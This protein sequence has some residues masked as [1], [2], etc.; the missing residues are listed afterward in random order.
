ML[1][2]YDLQDLLAA[3]APRDVWIVSSTD[4]LRHE[5]P[6]SEVKKEYRRA[7]EAFSQEGAAQAIRIRDRRPVRTSLPSTAN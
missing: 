1:K 5:L 6:A 3:L 7:L 4:P 2:S